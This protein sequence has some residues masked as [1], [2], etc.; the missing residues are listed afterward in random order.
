MED[1]QVRQ[2]VREELHR[3]LGAH[4]PGD[5]VTE[6]VGTLPPGE[7]RAAELYVRFARWWG[8]ERQTN[9]PSANWFGRRLRRDARVQ[10]KR[11]ASSRFYVVRAL[12]ASGV[13]GQAAA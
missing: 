4:E 5:D 6:F 11:G 13:V 2:I 10:A 9:T 1:A 8:T 3:M 12:P 7:Y